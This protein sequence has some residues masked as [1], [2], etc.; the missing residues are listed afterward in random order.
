MKNVIYGILLSTISSLSFAQQNIV[1]R[2][3]DTS[4]LISYI[5]I[6]VLTKGS[7]CQKT[8]L[9]D[10]DKSDKMVIRSEKTDKKLVSMLSGSVDSNSAAVKTDEQKKRDESRSVILAKE[11][12]EEL[13]QL[14]SLQK[15]LKNIEGSKDSEQISKLKEMQDRHS[16]NIT[17]LKKE[18]GIKEGINLATKN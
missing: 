15:M 3:T 7:N 12:Q 17:A 8:D 16:K 18:L 10:P 1:Y 9:A 5:N 13:N 6:P 2:C 11:L 4:G 14:V